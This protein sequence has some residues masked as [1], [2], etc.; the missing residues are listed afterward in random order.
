MKLAVYGTLRP[1][2]DEQGEHVNNTWGGALSNQEYLGRATLPDNLG[3]FDLGSFP[4]VTQV[5][6]ELSN[7]TVCDVYEIDETALMRCD[8]IEGHP[9]FYERRLVDIAGYGDC[10]VYILDD[11]GGKPIQ[12]GDWYDR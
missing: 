7:P 4:A 10:Y 1:H 6:Y 12:S 11:H 3:I 8:R 9:N 5:G 2:I